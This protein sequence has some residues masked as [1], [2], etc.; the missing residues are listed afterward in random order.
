VHRSLSTEALRLLNHLKKTDR[1]LRHRRQ[2]GMGPRPP[3]R[4]R[5]WTATATCPAARS[6]GCA[7]QPS[8]PRTCGRTAC[9]IPLAA[10]AIGAASAVS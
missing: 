10:V 7:P 6:R 4:T 9:A 2:L 3:G 8:S 5:S 1:Q